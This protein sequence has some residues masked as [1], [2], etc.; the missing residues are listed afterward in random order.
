MFTSYLVNAAG[1]LTTGGALISLVASMICGLVI[2][3]LY[4]VRSDY[5]KNFVI[6]L[7]ILPALVQ[8]VITVVNGN[9]GASV[10]VMGAFSLVR[11]RSAPGSAKDIT[12][13]FFA[14]AVGLANGMGYILYSATIVGIVGVIYL[15]LTL[16]GF[17]EHGVREKHL[18]V[19]IPESLDYTTVFDDI[20]EK[21]VKRSELTK[22]KTT[23]LGSIFELNYQI[24]LKDAKQEKEFLDALRT[25]NGNLT[26]ICSRAVNRTV[27]E[28]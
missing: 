28:I 26:I 25:K 18:K 11:F 21:Y 27:E 5:S 2:A 22:V 15:F 24:T 1:E 7:V 23:D 8:V 17:G 13:I 9:L 16:S 14:M 19:L 4:M 6:A 10:A 20:F 3:A 12:A